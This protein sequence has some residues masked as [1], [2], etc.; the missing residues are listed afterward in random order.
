MQVQLTAE[1]LQLLREVL[2]HEH[3]SLREEIYKTDTREVKSAL[4]A[5]EAT[6]VALL[7]KLGA[8]LPA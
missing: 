4:K 5:R 6:L 2:E 7:E 1:E 8:S 3:G